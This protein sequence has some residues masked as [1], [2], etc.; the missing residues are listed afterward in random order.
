MSS[1]YVLGIDIGGTTTKLA[2]IR[3]VKREEIVD[4]ATV[5]TLPNEPAEALIERIA[6][7]ARPLIAKSHVPIEGVGVGC[8]GLIDSRRGVVVLCSNIPRLTGFALRSQLSEALAL[9]V[10]IQ[11]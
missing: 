7:A 3:G 8:P 6:A 1:P 5:D 4:K 9:P 11:N 2:I 10:E